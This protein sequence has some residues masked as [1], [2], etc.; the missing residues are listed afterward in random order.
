MAE[1]RETREVPRRTVLLAG[2]IVYNR[3]HFPC[4]VR[5][6]SV[7]GLQVQ[8]DTP[9]AVG[10]PVHAELPRL[11]RFPAV[12]AWVDGQMMGLVFPEGAA[13]GLARFGE[14][15][16]RLGLVEPAAEAADARVAPLPIR[17]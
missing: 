16:V 10:T 8:T 2:S 15:A 4:R 9:L 1:D 3:Q 12:V 5:N 17:R 11:G 6:V 7:A 13:G 14:A